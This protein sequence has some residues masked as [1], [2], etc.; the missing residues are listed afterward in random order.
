MRVFQSIVFVAILSMASLA[1]AETL[2]I[3]VKETITTANAQAGVKTL[4]DLPQAADAYVSTRRR[5]Y[6]VEVRDGQQIADDE[7]TNR[8]A[9]TGQTVTSIKHSNESFGYIKGQLKRSPHRYSKWG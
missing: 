8:L 2:K 3:T 1:N 4:R 7:V 9:K 6:A 5:M